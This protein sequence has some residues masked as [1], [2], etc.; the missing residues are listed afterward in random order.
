MSAGLQPE[1]SEAPVLGVEVVDRERDVAVA[2]AVLIRLLAALVDRELD[3]EV[4]LGVA[5][6]DQREVVE[7]EAVRELQPERLA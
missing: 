1:L 7:V 2:V 5:Q 3:L 4:V 6:I